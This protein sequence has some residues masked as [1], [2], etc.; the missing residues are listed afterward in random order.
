[1]LK[2]VSIFTADC[3]PSSAFAGPTA[4]ERKESAKAEPIIDL[5]VLR[6]QVLP[7]V[8]QASV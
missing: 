3:M 2:T 4:F 5:P 8:W 6:P 1:M 7:A